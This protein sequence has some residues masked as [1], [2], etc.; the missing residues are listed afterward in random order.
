MLVGFSFTAK[1]GK[2]AELER[3]L[4]NERVTRK[5]MQAM[6]AK[7][8][9]LFWQGDR[10]VRIV[11]LPDGAGPVDVAALAR[12]DPEIAAFLRAIGPLAEPGFDLDAPE[13]LA[14]FN[15]AIVMRQVFDLKA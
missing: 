14:A 6:G 15:K 8:N 4:N 13:T 9:T 5:L 1:P 12:A 11:E 3:V 10:M 2:A 7:R